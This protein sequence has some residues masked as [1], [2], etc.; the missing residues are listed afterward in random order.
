MKGGSSRTAR[1][2]RLMLVALVCGVPASAWA[3]AAPAAKPVPFKISALQI[4]QI[5]S[6]DVKLPPEFQMSLYEN[7]VEQVSK[8]KRFRNV[9]RDGDSSAASVPDL[10]TLHCTVSGFKQGS[11]MARQVTTV[12]GA[13]V[14]TVHMKFTG[15]D[16]AVLIEKDAK[17]KVR[18]F[19][20]N[21]RATYDFGKKV[22]KIVRQDF[23]SSVPAISTGD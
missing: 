12:M 5:Q 1:G 8:T 23:A 14:I 9:F 17:G 11:A 7:V 15:K 2:W 13:T 10:V 16:G 22:A 19:G 3:Q 21:L 4:E 6:E 18:F 20:E